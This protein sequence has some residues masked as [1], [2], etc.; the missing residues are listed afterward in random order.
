MVASILSNE[1]PENPNLGDTTTGTELTANGY[2]E[3]CA[4]RLSDDKRCE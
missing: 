2:R 3:V 4:T 1:N